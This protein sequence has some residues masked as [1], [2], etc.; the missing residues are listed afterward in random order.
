MMV[1]SVVESKLVSSLLFEVEFL[2]SGADFWPLG[3]SLG[4]ESRLRR[5]LGSRS[6][7]CCLGHT[8]R[9][10]RRRGHPLVGEESHSGR[11]TEE[12]STVE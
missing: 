6:T 1:R 4:L 2:P 12:T 5:K 11:G 10:R 7:G 9:R 8:T 3:L